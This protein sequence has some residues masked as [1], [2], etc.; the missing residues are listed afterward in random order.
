MP[1]TFEF[2]CNSR[3]AISGGEYPHQGNVTTRKKDENNHLRI[4]LI[5]V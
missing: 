4:R 3:H 1:G 5:S 2:F